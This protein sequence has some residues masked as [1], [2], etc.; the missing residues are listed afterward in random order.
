MNAE[1]SIPTGSC[2]MYH[3]EGVHVPRLRVTTNGETTF[4]M[5]HNPQYELQLTA[6][7]HGKYTCV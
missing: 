3:P 2:K 7:V 5:L 4:T 1:D 6:V